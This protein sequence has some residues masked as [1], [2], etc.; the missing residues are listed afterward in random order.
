MN[1]SIV[2]LIVGLVCLTVWLTIYML[3]YSNMYIKNKLTLFMSSVFGLPVSYSY[4]VLATVIYCLLPLISCFVLGKV[5]GFQVSQLFSFAYGWRTLLVILLAVIGVMSVMAVF[6]MIILT[7][8][9]K[10][11]IQEEMSR[12]KWIEGI[13]M[14]PTKVAWLLPMCSACFEEIFFRG[15]FLKG[16]LVSGMGTV[17]AVSIVSIAFIVNQCIL[18]DTKIQKLVLGVSSLAISM[19]G[20]I[21]F[22]SCGSIHDY[23]CIICR[24]L[25]KW[26]KVVQ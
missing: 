21:A 1:K 18:A 2:V 23:A 13:F 8:S 17:L 20:S 16:L 24:V 22:L 5:A 14:V 26:E 3:S 9:P 19:I 6:L 10:M 4:S 25:H 12:I 15:A 7:I 11:N